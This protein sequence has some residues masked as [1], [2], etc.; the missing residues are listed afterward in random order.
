MELVLHNLSVTLGKTPI[1]NHINLNLGK[2]M[3]LSLLGPSGSGKSTL[4]KTIAGLVQAQEGDILLKGESVLDRPA[5]RRGAVIVFQDLRLF[6]HMSV[7]ENVAFGLR[8]QGV[9]KAERLKT[10]RELLEQVQLPGFGSRRVS[11]LSGGQQQRV[12]LAR[13]LATKPSLLLLDEPF[14]S[15]DED[16][17][18]DMR[19][20]VKQLHTD[21]GMTTILVTH[22][23]Q[24]ALSMSDQ[25]AVMMNGK[26][27]QMGTPQQVYQNPASRQV[28]D[29]FGRWC[30]LDG[31]V[32][33]GLFTSGSFTLPVS[34]PDG[35]YQLMLRPDGVDFTQDGPLSLRLED[36]QFRGQDSLSRWSIQGGQKLEI[37]LSEGHGFAVGQ[38]CRCGLKQDKVI[39]YPKQKEQL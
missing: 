8:M 28:A 9:A 19:Q 22:D 11:T 13:A 7:E 12:A 1:L 34:H 4:L 31:T 33:N 14:S 24:E 15:L 38:T 20:L 6:G 18:Q 37:P 10:A 21:H 35:A 36:V 32:E 16:L 2:G 23:R 27:L 39:L 3:F 17:R 30:Y 5:H 29:Y 26:L 25:V